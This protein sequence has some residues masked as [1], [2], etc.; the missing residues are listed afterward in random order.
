MPDAEGWVLLVRE[1]KVSV[2]RWMDIS[3]I[4]ILNVIIVDNNIVVRA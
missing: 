2:L 1:Y 3:E 4:L